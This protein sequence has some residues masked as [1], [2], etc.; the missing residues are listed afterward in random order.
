MAIQSLTYLDIPVAKRK[1]AA[2]K[3][4]TLIRERL[5]DPLVTPAQAQKMMARLQQLEQWA[6]D[7]SPSEGEVV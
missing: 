2:A 1:D 5:C 4:S 6:L 7:V 3:A